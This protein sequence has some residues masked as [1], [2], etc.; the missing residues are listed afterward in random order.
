MPHIATRPV[1]DKSLLAIG[2]PRRIRNKIH[3]RNVAAKPCLICEEVPCHAHHVTFA[4]PRGL[5]VKVSD[6][7]TVP[8]C[9]THHNEVHRT[10]S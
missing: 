5:S 8:L 6:E 3:L 7:Y 10:P 2:S 9:A 4:Q 1:I